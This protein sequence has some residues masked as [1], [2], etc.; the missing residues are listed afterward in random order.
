MCWNEPVSWTTFAVGT[1][2]SIISASIIRKPIII[3]ISI[4]W[5][6][7]LLMQVF[8]ALMWRDQDCGKLNKFA[9]TGAYVANIMQ[10]IIV[11]IVLIVVCNPPLPYKITASVVIS[12]YTC[13][14]LAQVFRMKPDNCTQKCETGKDCKH[15]Y[16]KWWDKMKA[17]GIIYVIALVAVILLLCR[18]IWF[19]LFEVGYILL[20]LLFASRFFGR[21][22][23]S[24][25]FWLAVFAPLFTIL[26]WKISER[27]EFKMKSK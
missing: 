22:T 14:M 1:A 20:T 8:E 26:F 18:P 24:T 23:A 27:I 21:S 15:L 4:A 16:Y 10:P 19:G 13:Y 17:G 12:V 5:I 9:T 25:W 3:A 2:L 7:A 6:W 11:F